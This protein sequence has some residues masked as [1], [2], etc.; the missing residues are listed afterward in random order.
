[1]MRLRA[2]RLA[3]VGRFGAP[4]AV[5][6]FGDGLNVLTAD[7]EFG[8]STL[9]RALDALMRFKFSSDDKLVH[10]LMPNTGGAPLIEAE[11]EAE[12]TSWRLRKRF[13]SGRSA[14]LL[15]LGSGALLRNA[16]AE[17]RLAALRAGA[18]NFDRFGLLWVRQSIVEAPQD[19]DGHLAALMATEVDAV[20]MDAHARAIHARVRKELAELQTDR[21]RADGRRRPKA[22]GA[23]ALALEA[24]EKAAA[25]LVKAEADAARQGDRLAELARLA[26][27]RAL[28]MAPHAVAARDEVLAAAGKR[29][30]DAVEARR[31]RT[32]AERL[33][34]TAQE[35]LHAALREHKAITGELAT[36][37]RL[38]RE[39]AAARLRGEQLQSRSEEAR[40]AFAAAEARAELERDLLARRANDLTAATAA[41]RAQQAA[42]QRDA[43]SVQ[44]DAVRSAMADGV[45]AHAASASLHAVTPERVKA[46]AAA[47]RDL[48]KIEAQ[49]AAVV[50]EVSIALEGGAAGRVRVGGQPLT[51]GTVYNPETPL[52][53]DIAG[54][55]RITVAPNRAAVSAT[56]RAARAARRAEIEAAYAG[57]G[58]ATLADAEARLADRQRAESR[59]DEAQLRARMLAPRGLEALLAEHAEL[60]ACAADSAA[61]FD[62]SAVEKAG[63]AL[64]TQRVRVAQCDTALAGAR[65]AAGE[66]AVALAGQE[67]ADAERGRQLLDLEQ[68]LGDATARQKALS[69]IEQKVAA[70]R[71][72]FTEASMAA[73]AWAAS[74]G[75]VEVDALA[76]AVAEARRAIRT[77][78]ERCVAIDIRIGGIDGELRAASDEDVES[79]LENARAAAAAAAAHLA[80]IEADLSALNLL[81]R[82]FDALAEAGRREL[83]G[84]ILKRVAPYLTQL[85]PDAHLELDGALAPSALSRNGRAEPHAQLS[86][87]TREQIAILVRLGLAH[88]LADKG[89][90]I[91]LILDDALVYS[92]DRRIAEM[93]RMLREAALRHQVIVLNCRAQTFAPLAQAAGTTVLSLK[94]W[95]QPALAA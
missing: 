88:L 84:P 5:E 8:K 68:K 45:A 39:R 90:A 76:A 9:L 58:V 1:M 13:L 17:L 27:E 59:A 35:A 80:E 12:G 95:A 85:F 74:Q 86:D 42:K 71:T 52:E 28:L 57:L 54:I 3:E 23:W 36:L 78:D 72:C 63:K 18:L 79:E 26:S 91:P 43:L 32:E 16:D 37:D 44:I 65:Q 81:D 47:I 53:I 75:G 70:A 62:P 21:A 15:D 7:N 50:P 34:K 22:K 51:A 55:G 64:E 93:F 67:A 6:G 24:H 92:D 29:H 31:R 49:F 30:A 46:L 77:A 48:E 94:P 61:D 25:R 60:G 69:E 4:V 10:A 2:L 56:Q 11:F 87:G 33:L 20:A 41:G 14:S 38:S 83:S 89:A 82:E 40:A 66:V 73:E 19:S